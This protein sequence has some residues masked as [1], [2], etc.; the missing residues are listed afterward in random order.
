MAMN[1]YKPGQGY[2]TRLLS[3][4]GFGVLALALVAWLWDQTSKL[5]ASD[6]ESLKNNLLYIQL[7]VAVVFTSVFGLLLYRFIGTK[8]RSCDFMIATE[9]EMKKVNW[10][11]QREVKGA[12]WIVIAFV[13]LLVALLFAADSL[14]ALF[15]ET[16]GVLEKAK[17]QPPG[18]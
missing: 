1:V 8:P 10:P 2:W 9:G 3:A 12:T 5:A 18:A 15:F 14:F 4:I 16:I 7:G 11:S 6:S 13:V 17:V